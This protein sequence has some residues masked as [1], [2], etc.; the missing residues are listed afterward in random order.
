MGAPLLTF[1]ESY[2]PFTI[3]VYDLD[4][5]GDD[6]VITNSTDNMWLEQTQDTWILQNQ[7]T[8]PP[9][10]ANI[11][12]YFLQE[13]ADYNQDG[14]PDKILTAGWGDGRQSSMIFYGNNQ[15][16]IIG[17][18]PGST[19]GDVFGHA[20]SF[21]QQDQAISVGLQCG[22]LVVEYKYGR[23]S[24]LLRPLIRTRSRSMS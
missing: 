1:Y 14:V 16:E 20:L 21:E 24:S 22:L 19:G 15:E 10:S 2:G 11:P 12:G 4:G 23:P 3:E 7:N 18:I 13:I 6:D 9:Y 17:L 8:S 5:D